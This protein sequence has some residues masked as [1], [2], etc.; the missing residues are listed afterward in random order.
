MIPLLIGAYLLGSIPFAV[1]FGRIK[2]VDILSFGSGNPGMTNVVRALGPGWGAAC[3]VLDVL[4]GLV[5]ATAGRLVVS[6]PIHGL[7]P[8]LLW[9]AAGLAAIIGHC[10]SVFLRFRG[11][12]GV[13]TAL[14][15]IIGTSPMVACCC[16]ALFVL[17]LAVTRYM[18][19]A[20]VTGV[21]SAVVFDILVPEQSRQLLP[22]FIALSVFVA[23]RHRRNFQ[24]LRDGTEPRFRFKKS[25]PDATEI[26]RSKP[27]MTDTG[28]NDA[29]RGACR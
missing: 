12:K 13:S 28:D 9:F 2:G 14:G 11:G 16:F 3:F 23:I 15:A 1:I 22:V 29:E 25:E 27:E 20:S 8:Q 26:R 6:H 10:A 5:P 21:A 24:R 4:K 7:D 18:A 17:V 19:V